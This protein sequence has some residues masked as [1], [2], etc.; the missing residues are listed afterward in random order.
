MCP[1]WW[2]ILNNLLKYW[3]ISLIRDNIFIIP[4]YINVT[5]KFIGLYK[6]VNGYQSKALHLR[7]IFPRE[8]VGRR[9]HLICK[10]DIF[11]MSN[12]KW[13]FFHT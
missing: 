3:H 6:I 1:A 10:M 8:D 2:V 12:V 5:G 7:N 11:Y 13:L 9:I 4:P